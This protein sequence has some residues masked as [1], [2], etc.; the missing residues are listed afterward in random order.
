MTFTIAKDKSVKDILV[1]GKAL[2][3][4]KVYYVVTSDYLSN[5]GDNMTFFKKGVSRTDIDYKLRNIMIDYFKDVDTLK[6]DSTI[7]ITK[8]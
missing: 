6:I 5:G 1:Q 3:L 2:D 4:N 8:E 7:R